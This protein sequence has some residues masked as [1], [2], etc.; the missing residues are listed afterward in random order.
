MRNRLIASAAALLA[1]S[2]AVVGLQPAGATTP[3]WHIRSGA[4]WLK[5][6]VTHGFVPYNNKRDLSDTVQ[7]ATALAAAVNDGAPGGAV[8]RSMADYLST[9]VNKYV[10]GNLPP[11]ATNDNAGALARV[12]LLRQ[13][14]GAANPTALVARLEATQQTSGLFGT[15]DPTYDGTLRQGLSMVALHAA[16]VGWSDPLMVKARTWLLDQQCPNGGFSA[17]KASP[18]TGCTNDPAD[19]LGPD[20]NS[21]AIALWAL[22]TKNGA[23]SVLDSVTSALGFLATFELKHA[24][25]S[26]LPGGAADCDSTALV[27][28]ALFETSQDVTAT[29]GTWAMNGTSPLAGLERFQVRPLDTPSTAGGFRFQLTNDYPKPDVLSSEQA[30]LTLSIV[31]G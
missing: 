4:V 5:S 8:L 27:D 19:Y 29:T 18:S 28:L 12:I 13:A 14:M 9:R 15:S 3:S 22:S 30:L 25:W 11:S 26:F 21:T 24:T 17:D 6:Q 7:S 2:T 1:L 20:T 23:P 31:G 10:D 16:G